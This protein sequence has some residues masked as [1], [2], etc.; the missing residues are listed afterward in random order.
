MTSSPAG[1]DCGADCSEAYDYNT[2]VTLTPARIRARPSPAGRV[3]PTARRLVT[4]TAARS[5][6]ATFTLDTHTLTVPRPVPAAA[7]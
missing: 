3:T 6:T 2:V 5:C 7:R 1:I 4:M